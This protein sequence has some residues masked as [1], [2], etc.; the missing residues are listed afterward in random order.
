MLTD[1]QD[2]LIREVIEA[3]NSHYNETGKRPTKIHITRSQH[4]QAD[5]PISIIGLKVL[6]SDTFAIS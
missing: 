6:I 4:V 5:K 1:K 3:E 2:K